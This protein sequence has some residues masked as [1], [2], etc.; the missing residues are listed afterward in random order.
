VFD[1]VTMGVMEAPYV[2]V[3]Y[4]EWGIGVL[5]SRPHRRRPRGCCE[6]EDD[7]GGGGLSG[8]R[9]GLPWELC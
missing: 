4:R 2:R 7:A 5:R 8:H 3:R 1:G 9:M 6:E